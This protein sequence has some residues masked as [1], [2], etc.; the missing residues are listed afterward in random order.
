MAD[1]LLERVIRYQQNQIIDDM[2]VVVS[3]VDHYRP[4]WATLHMPGLSRMERPRTVS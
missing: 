2:T 1:L 3:Q 4:E